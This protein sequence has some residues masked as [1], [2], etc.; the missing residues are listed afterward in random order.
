MINE[1]LYSLIVWSKPSLFSPWAK[2]HSQ[3]KLLV[4]FFPLEQKTIGNSTFYDTYLFRIFFFLFE[5]QFVTRRP[6]PRVLQITDGNNHAAPK[7]RY[8]Y[9]HDPKILIEKAERLN[10]ILY[11]KVKKFM[12]I[13]RAPRL[14]P[15]ACR[16]F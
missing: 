12:I 2:S 7:C 1:Q 9:L 15:E 13:A 3:L 14:E 4:I 6:S 8:Y 5:V 10:S 16:G 11:T